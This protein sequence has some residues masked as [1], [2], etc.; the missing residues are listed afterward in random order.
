MKVLKFLRIDCY[1]LSTAMGLGSMGLAWRL[2]GMPR[3]SLCGRL[4]LEYGDLIAQYD[5]TKGLHYI[6]HN[7]GGKE[8]RT[9]VDCTTA[10]EVTVGPE[11]SFVKRTLGNLT[12]ENLYWLKV[13]LNY[14]RLLIK[15][16]AVY[17]LHPIKYIK[18]RRNLKRL[19]GFINGRT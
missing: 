2:D 14:I 13:A 11:P 19:G 7:H 10:C 5:E 1:R 8:G 15:E 3:C 12:L 4:S 16:K 18:Y 17:I 6:C 9:Y